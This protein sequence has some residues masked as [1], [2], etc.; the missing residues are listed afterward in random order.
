MPG[1]LS[2]GK[3]YEIALYHDTNE[4]RISYEESMVSVKYNSRIRIDRLGGLQPD[5]NQHA[6]RINNIYDHD[7]SGRLDQY[8]HYGAGC[9]GKV[10]HISPAF[11]LRWE[12]SAAQRYGP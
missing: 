9:S 7:D 4:E 12:Q 2:T 5:G 10:D 11:E 1:R 3:Q 8:D 6:G